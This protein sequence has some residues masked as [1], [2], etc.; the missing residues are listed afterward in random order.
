MK[1]PFEQMAKALIQR[2]ALNLRALALEWMREKESSAAWDQPQ[3]DDAHIFIAAAALA[4]LFA[5][6]LNLPAPSW[7]ARAGVFPEPFYALKAANR[8]R[9]VRECC[10]KDTPACFRRHGI[11]APSNFLNMA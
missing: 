9:S 1:A 10:E 2:D 8:L 11:F 7:T 6:R 4:E 5:E 3:S